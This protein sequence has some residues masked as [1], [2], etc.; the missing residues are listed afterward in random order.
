MP[1][2]ASAKDLAVRYAGDDPT[3]LAK[4]NPKPLHDEKNSYKV[5]Q[6]YLTRDY[7]AGF[8]TLYG[9]GRGFLVHVWKKQATK[10][11]GNDGERELAKNRAAEKWALLEEE[12]AGR[13]GRTET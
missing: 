3:A 6:I 8:M 10:S 2:I 12:S 1:S 4:F 9:D 11:K 13:K 7:R 5:Q